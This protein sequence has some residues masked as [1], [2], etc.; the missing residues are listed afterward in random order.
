MKIFINQNILLV[1]F[2]QNSSAS[3]FCFVGG[4][5]SFAGFIYINELNKKKTNF[6]KRK[7]VF[8]FCKYVLEMFWLLRRTRKYKK[9]QG[10]FI[11]F[12]VISLKFLFAN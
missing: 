2:R 12:P 7:E 3:K 6:Y 9:A 1:V 5:E 10:A 8:I 4:D 11:C